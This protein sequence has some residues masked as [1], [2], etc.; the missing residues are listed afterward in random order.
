MVTDSTNAVMETQEAG[1][2]EG[3]K[4]DHEITRFDGGILRVGIWVTEHDD[5]RL[6]FSVTPTCRYQDKE[7]NWHTAKSFTA[8]QL[9]SLS[10]LFL[11]ADSWC[12]AY[13]EKHYAKKKEASETPF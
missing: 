3:R 1:R 4:P 8:Q 2:A 10:K 7:K 13:R 11:Q 5:G 9:L 6:A 12:E